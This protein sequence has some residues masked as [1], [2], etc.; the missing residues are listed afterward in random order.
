M[1]ADGS[2]GEELRQRK[3][4]SSPGSKDVRRREK[5]QGKRKAETS[6]KY[7]G[8]QQFTKLF[9]GCLLT[10]TIG[11]VY[12]VYLSTFHER[13]FWVSNRR[14]VDR[15]ITFQGDGAIYYSFYKDLLRA[16]TLE[17]GIIDLIYNNKTIP[18]RTINAMKQLTLY[19][20][21]LAS[22][23]LEMVGRHGVDPVYFYLGMIFGL[24]GIYLGALFVTSWLMSGTWLAGVLTAGWFIINRADTTRIEES[25]PLRENWA[26][27]YFACQVAALT[28]FLRHNSNLSV[29]RFCFML[30][31]ATTYIFMMMWEYSHYLLFVQALSLCLLDGL[32]LINK[33]KVQEMR[34]TYLAAVSMGYLLQFENSALLTSPLLSL[35]IATMIAENLQSSVLSR[36]FQGKV[37]TMMY[38]CVAFTLT[39]SLNFLMGTLVTHKQ[40]YQILKSLGVKFGLKTTKN[41]TVNW[42]LCRE[43]FQSLSQDCLLRL[44]QSSLLPFYVL[45]LIVCLI[46]MSQGILKRLRGDPVSC[47][48]LPEE[49]RVGE[50]PEVSYHVVQ[51]LI[52]GLLA[53]TF[54]GLKYLWTP[55]V[56]V[57]AA[58]GVCSPALWITLFRW[59]RLRT[60][61]PVMLACVLSATVPAVIGFSLWREFLPR[62]V[63]ELSELEEHYESDTVE[64]MNWIKN[65]APVTAVIA[66]SPQLMGDIKLCT[67]WMVTSLPVYNDEE[68]M[69]RNEHMYQIYSMRSAEDIYKI[70]TTYKASYMV[71][72]ESICNEVLRMDNCR[73][74][75][76]L[77][78][79]NDHVVTEEDGDVYAY[80][81]YGRFCQEIKLNRSPYVNYFTRVY[82]NRSYFVYK[83]NTV[84][85]FQS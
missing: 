9:V 79:A 19:P 17:R 40:N 69:S 5:T 70:L 73:V 41:F 32:S 37:M 11:M 63:G 20:E 35:V 82:W 48:I 78:N 21:V 84:I 28:G 7:V 39:V 4:T 72:E 76:L 81:E 65:H 29:E 58:F 61:H 16:P 38:F 33:E 31:C 66:A 43:S 71:I 64:V 60:V 50:R 34:K 13:K 18:L 80:S 25:V 6:S 83:I 3:N 36:N 27:P 46:S 14:D 23:M 2:Q 62:I 75:D 54:E 1:E 44:T 68:L 59:L 77:D 15:E 67:G 49:G 56:C 26:L 57:L 24:Q 52:L 45:V 55:Y 22:A 42:L 85:A 8:F 74:K 47:E 53:I 51:S 30:M 10:V 12:A